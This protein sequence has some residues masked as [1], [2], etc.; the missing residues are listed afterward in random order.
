MNKLKFIVVFVI[1][2]F[3]GF[4]GYSQFDCET[5]QCDCDNVPDADKDPGLKALCEYYESSMIE[6]CENG[7]KD[8]KCHK[9]AKG[10]N[11]WQELKNNP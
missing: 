11:A 6:L 10:P 4:T 7:E 5:I 2:V 8:L 3:P 1:L 9:S